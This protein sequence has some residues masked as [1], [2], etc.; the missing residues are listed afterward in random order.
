M[1][2]LF[3]SQYFHPEPFSNTDIARELKARGHDVE[4]VCCV[5]NYPSGNF[6]QGY[7][8]RQRREDEFDGVVIHRAWTFARGQRA[9]TLALNYLIFPVS[10]TWTLFRKITKK[11]DVSFVSSLSPVFQAMPAIALRRVRGV[12]MVMWVQ[13]IWPESLTDTIELKSSVANRLVSWLSGWIYRRADLV[14]VQSHAFTPMI[15]RFGISSQKIRV[16]PNTAPAGFLPKKPTAGSTAGQLV[17]Q[18]G[19]RLMFAGNIGEAQ[20]FDT[21]IE[22]AYLLKDRTELRWVIVGTGRDLDRVKILTVDRGVAHK[23]HFLG[24]FPSDEMPQ[25]FAHADAMLVSLKDT[26]IFARTV[27]YKIQGYL[28]CGKP[29]IA[30]LNGEGPR[31]L[32]EANAGFACQAQSPQDL[33][34]AILKM[35]NSSEKERNKMGANGLAYF[36]KNYSPE[37]VYGDLEDWLSQTAKET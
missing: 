33:A 3:L 8:N 26:K 17:P 29:I 12:P 14:L 11:P 25:F 27:P 23:F 20:D 30:S 24:R 37:K 32:K 18:D 34:E 1:K 13:D 5:P 22:A 19:F 15:E 31:I 36:R 9:F 28:A 21:L 10:G 35:L 7:S 2:V 16:L 6:Y 4:T